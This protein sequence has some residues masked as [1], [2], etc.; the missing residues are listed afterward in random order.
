MSAELIIIIVGAILL[1]LA[2]GDSIKIKGKPLGLV[3]PKL[4]V[5]LGIIGV[6]LIIYGGFSYGTVNLPG[7]LE[8]AQVGNVKQI[9]YP[10]NAVQV[11][12][13]VEGDS[14]NCRILTM[15]VYPET[16]D[17][18]IWV[19][20]RPSDDRY[21]PQSDHTNTSYKRDGEWQ[22]ITRFGGDK[23]EEFEVIVYETDATASQFF[24]TTI[25]DWKAALQYPGLELQEIPQGATEVDRLKVTL[26]KNC[27]GAHE[28]EDSQ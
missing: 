19:V 22:V 8:Q 25:A 14:V 26:N 7:Q 1:L 23:D 4:K 18:D 27:R 21:Y 15:G 12:S 28:T 6:L 13:P 17:K 5:P 9:T 20:L 16:H 2:F 24:S 10:V 11:L 3:N